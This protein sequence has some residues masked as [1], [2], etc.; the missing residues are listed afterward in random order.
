MT[1]HSQGRGPVMSVLLIA[2]LI[3]G[4]AGKPPKELGGPI[5]D[6]PTQGGVQASP[7]RYV[8]REVRWGGEILD[9]H[10]ASAH[11]DVEIYGRP[12]EGNAEPEPAGGDGV[13]F[14]ARV[15]RF[16]DPVEYAPGK[17]LTV[18]GRLQQAVTRTV[19][20]FPYRYPLVAVDA[21]HLWPA[22][23]PPEPAYYPYH[24]YPYWGPW[25]PWGPW[26]PHRH[27]YWW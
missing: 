18:R 19:G 15:P 4:C 6:M 1:S 10:N 7:A 26:G 14:I 12:L 25:W 9:V 24:R 2:I 16:L 11:T 17:R 5:A 27:P 23:Q 22:Y 20:E 8:G 3:G 21:S 13:R